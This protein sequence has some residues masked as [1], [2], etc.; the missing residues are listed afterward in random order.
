ML[1]AK[2]NKAVSNGPWDGKNGKRS[3]LRKHDLLLLNRDLDGFSGNGWTDES[4][5]R[6][7]GEL[8]NKIIDIWRV[9]PGYKS[10]TVR[11]ATASM[12][13]VDLSDLLSGGLLAVGQTL[14]PRMRDLRERTAQ[15]L[16]DGRI[17]VDGHLFDTPSGAGH[18]VRGKAT[19]GWSFWLIDPRTKKSLA[20]VRREYVEKL[21]LESNVVEDEDYNDED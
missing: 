2:L 8:I 13:S 21:S 16:S 17:D 6:R 15:I 19:N 1:T 11:D 18:Y 7:T 12:Q 5:M 9:P 4:I 20:S 10:S 3:E 14:A